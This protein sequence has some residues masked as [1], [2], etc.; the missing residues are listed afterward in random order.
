ML[1]GGPWHSHEDLLY[2]G[3][4]LPYGNNEGKRRT[5]TSTIKPIE[6]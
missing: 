4:Q 5:K 6:K 2:L 3:K 1:N